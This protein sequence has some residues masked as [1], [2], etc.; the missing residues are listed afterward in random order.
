MINTGLKIGGVYKTKFDPRPYRI[1]GLDNYE[2]F[3]DCLWSDNKWTFSDNFKVKTIFYRMPVDLFA[4]K[5]ELIEMK[6]L[7]DI[8]MKY[9]RPDLQMRFGRTKE[10]NW[11]SIDSIG[12]SY[13]DSLFQGTK[14]PINKLVLVPY[15][16]KG[17]LLKGV[18]IESDNEFTIFEIINKA[19]IIQSISNQ[20][21]SKGIGFYRL[22]YEKGLPRYSIGEF[23]D[24]AGN[25]KE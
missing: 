4:T 5:S 8:E 10:V 18:V 11:N 17:A 20:Q 14:I 6:E 3:Y 12:L 15:G 1:I 24:K 21:V 23:L 13:L 22:G 9:F 19:M 2:V 16:P 7:T 25:I